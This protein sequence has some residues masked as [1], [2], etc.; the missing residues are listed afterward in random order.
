MTRQFRPDLYSHVARHVIAPLWALKE[1]TPY[2]MHL[3]ALKGSSRRPFE[4][5]RL[6][7]LHCFKSLL[8]HAYETT[9]FYRER[10]DEAGIDPHS[11]SSMDDLS[12]IPLLTKDDIRRNRDE[13]VSDSVDR[14][15]LVAIKTSGSTGVSLK[16]FMDETSRQWKRACAV[17]FDMW[18]GWH[19]GERVG[20]IWGNPESWQNWRMWLR[21]FLLVRH[22]CLDT[23]KMDEGTMRRYCRTLLDK[24]PTI[25]FGHAH[26]LYLFALFLKKEGIEG[27]RPKGVISTAMVLHDFERVLMEEVFGCKVTNRYGCEEVS[28]IACECEAHSG[29]HV[30]MDS[31]VFECVD[32]DGNP[33]PT[34]EPGAVVVTDLTNF[35]MPIIRYKVGDMARM[36]AEPCPCGRTYPMIE[37]IEGRIADYIRTPDGHFVSG[38]SLTENFAMA[39]EGVKQL[40]IVQ[41]TYDCLTFRIVSDEEWDADQASRVAELVRERFGQQMRHE[42]EFVDSIQSESSGKY[43]FCISLL[44]QP[45]F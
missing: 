3:E 27:V 15:Q 43:R 16:L 29:L 36:S 13:M 20:A 11:W 40:Q 34:G 1:K 45:A 41:K 32:S 35:A 26:S 5:I 10:L 31:L 7:Q 33:V 19:L 28:L 23:L 18:A 12:R 14:S 39:L 22:V 42:I 44:E 25:L 9:P 30:N 8:V 6:E 38:I 17:R 24:Q 4:E 2:L 21:N 37:S